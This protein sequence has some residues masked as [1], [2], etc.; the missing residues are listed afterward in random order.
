MPRRNPAARAMALTAPDRS[1]A[2]RECGSAREGSRSARRTTQNR[3]DPGIEGSPML[4]HNV[5]FTLKDD[6]ADACQRLVDA[7][8]QYLSDHPGTAFFAAGV[9]NPDLA[10][11][12]NDRG[13]H[14]ALHV[15]FEDRAAH[16]VY[17]DA[18]RHQQFIAENKD[19]W[20]SVR[21]FDSDVE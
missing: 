7:C 9:L 13:F 20:A 8:H 1:V 12:V 18:D 5:Y 6:S 19:N 17:Q 10:R 15:I 4:A 21:V 3:S 14:V 2:W 11:P 16:D